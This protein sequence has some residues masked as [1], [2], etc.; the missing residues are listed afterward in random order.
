MQVILFLKYKRVIFLSKEKL[1]VNISILSSIHI[2]FFSIFKNAKSFQKKE[3]KMIL[4]N[5]EEMEKVGSRGPDKR[6]WQET[7]QVREM[8]EA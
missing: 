5:E 8:L 4:E 7:V 6:L 3:K 1:A 2:G